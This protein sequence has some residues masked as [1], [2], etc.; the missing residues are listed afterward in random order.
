M[1]KS[2]TI[3]GGKNENEKQENYYYHRFNSRNNVFTFTS[4][5]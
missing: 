2:Q 4:S 3:L 1:G 5:I